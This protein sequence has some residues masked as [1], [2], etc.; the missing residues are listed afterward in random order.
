[1]I[2][3]KHSFKSETKYKVTHRT[4]DN[5]K[6][7]TAKRWFLCR[8]RRFGDIP[9]YCFSSRIA[10]NTIPRQIISIPQYDLI[11]TIEL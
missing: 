4:F 2:E 8:E 10:R 3:F 7:V 6:T 11:K 9:C 5:S 1:M